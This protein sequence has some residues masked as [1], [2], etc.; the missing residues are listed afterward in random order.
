[1]HKVVSEQIDIIHAHEERQY[2][3]RKRI[4]PTPCGH[5][6]IVGDRVHFARNHHRCK[7]EREQNVF[8]LEFHASKRVCRDNR[9]KHADCR[10][11]KAHDKRIDKDLHERSRSARRGLAQHRLVV[12]PHKRVREERRHGL[13]IFHFGFERRNYHPIERQE[14][15]HRA[16]RQNSVNEHVF[17][18]VADFLFSSLFFDVEIRYV[19]LKNRRVGRNRGHGLVERGIFC[20]DN[21]HFVGVVFD[22]VFFAEIC[23]FRFGCC[24]FVVF[25][26]IFV[27][28]IGHSAPLRILLSFCLRIG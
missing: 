15:K 28:N 27:F 1:M 25:K 10:R 7:H 19:S 12:F 5:G 21:A 18:H 23:G 9:H 17:E 2:H 8:A 4:S 26:Q 3:D 11:E 13:T 22:N 6:E 24:I 16:N 20:A 14:R